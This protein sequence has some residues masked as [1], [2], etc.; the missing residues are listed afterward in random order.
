MVW[1]HVDGPRGWP[2]PAGRS[3]TTVRRVALDF[4]FDSLWSPA[5]ATPERSTVQDS[6]VQEPLN[7]G[8]SCGLG[9]GRCPP[10]LTARSLVTLT[11][12]RRVHF[13]SCT[14]AVQLCRSVSKPAR[15]TTHTHSSRL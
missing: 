9:R 6:L 3:A 7:I 11:L 10:L 13:T 1:R 2:A 8:F 5:P 4:D 12:H 14:T 15:T